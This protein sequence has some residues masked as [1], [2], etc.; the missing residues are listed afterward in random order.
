MNKVAAV[1]VTYNRKQLLKENISCLMSQT[2]REKMDIVIIDNH[3]SDGTKE[4]LNDFIK[5]QEILYR[6][7]GRNLG[8]AGGFSF[9]AR[10]AAECGYE[11]V[12]LMDDD[13]MPNPTALEAFLEADR[14]LKGNYGFLSSKVLWKD[15]KICKMNIQRKSLAKNV[16]DFQSRFS[17][18]FMASFVSLF[19]PVKIVLELGIPIQ[20]FFIWTDDWEYT[21]RI[22]RKYPCYLVNQSVVVHKS[23]HNFGASIENDVEGRL[24][25]Y[26]YLYRNDVY[27]YR[28]EGMSGFFY[29]LFRLSAHCLRVV[30]KAKNCRRKRIA[31][32][33]CGTAAG[34][35]FHPKITYIEKKG[36]QVNGF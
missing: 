1:V 9:G 35:R 22:S 27:L 25:R 13:C 8:G 16:T 26:R 36:D 29:E 10:F 30:V 34:L 14:D 2:L 19:L 23:E 20:E 28:R 4:V 11:Y 24:D 3:S 5:S 32:I 6:D 31:C 33:L 12:W 21:R 7:T 18:V 17:P 15:G